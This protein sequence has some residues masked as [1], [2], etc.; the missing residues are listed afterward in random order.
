MDMLPFKLIETLQLFINLSDIELHALASVM[1]E[2]HI[3]K[4]E[5]FLQQGQIC[6]HLGFLNK[7]IMRVYHLANDKEYTSYFNFGDRNP[8]VS[9]F[10]SFVTRQPSQESIHAL[11]DCEILQISYSN[12]QK[13][14]DENF[15]IQKMGRLIAEY[16]YTLAIKRIYS[17][18]HFTA[19]ERYNELLVIYPNIVNHVPHHYVASYLGITPESLSRIR[20]EK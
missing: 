14:Y 11:E 5:Y 4:G 7:G 3:K 8:F 6:H 20:K 15:A 18:Q 9:S 13:L 16:N 1:E 19:Q 12:L 17:L 2:R 10:S